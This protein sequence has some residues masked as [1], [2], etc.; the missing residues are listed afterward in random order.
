MLKHSLAL[1]GVALLGLCLPVY[2]EDWPQFRGPSG[3]GLAAEGKLPTEWG[4]G[5]NTTWK[6]PVPGSGWSSPIV[7][8]GRIYLTAAVA[9]SNGQKGDMVLVA[10]CM[11]AKTGRLLWEKDVFKQDGKKAPRIHD[12]NSHASP[13]PLIVGDKLYVHFGHQGTACLDLDGNVVWSNRDLTY[14][15]V[16]GNGGSPVV[17]D[18]ALIFSCD[19]GDKRFIAAL[20]R[21]TGKLL[22]QTERAGEA[23]RKF[24]F[25]TPLVITVAGK[26]QVISP[27]S[28]SVNAYDAATGQEIWHVRYYGYSVVP[29]PVYGH[30]L[31]YL[32]TGF[33]SPTLMAIKPDGQ[34]DVTDTHVAWKATKGAP[35]TPSP[36]LVGEELYMVSDSGTASCLNAKTGEVYWQQRLGGSFSAS[37][38]YGD[39]RVYFQNEKGVGVV[40]K[41]SK[42]FELVSK[43]DLEER[44]LASYAVADGALFI[45]SDKHLY[46]IDQK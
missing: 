40:V 13:T 46:R 5:K 31:V 27:G 32:S 45:R 30:G 28:N 7:V 18:D 25:S 16:H 9:V 11:E 1:I 26:K 17:V 20:N 12:K 14:Q 8:K 2:A 29:R 37:P 44:T 22:W 10:L 33:M 34:G 39:G 41:A 42:S 43:N 15:P 35:T 21:H 4:A 3:Q 19:G 6:A 38:V 24:S 23:D 36:L